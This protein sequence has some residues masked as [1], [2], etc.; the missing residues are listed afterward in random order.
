[1]KK[2]KL[3]LVPRM[4]PPTNLRKAGPH[5]QAMDEVRARV[6]EELRKLRDDG[7]D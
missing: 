4:G 6:K 3:A 1:M 2:K 7:V 5:K